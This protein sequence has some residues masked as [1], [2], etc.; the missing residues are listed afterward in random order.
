VTT[1]LLCL[2]LFTLWPIVLVLAI[3]AVRVSQVLTGKKPPNGFPSGTQHGSDWYWRLNRAHVNTLESLPVFASL[4]LTAAVLHLD[5]P[6]FATLATTV[7]AAR[8]G[9]TLAHVF[10]GGNMHVNVRFTFFVVQLTCF[11]WMGLK[12]ATALHA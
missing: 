1:S 3:G 2:V 9:Q 7:V 6:A 12:L 11:L 5:D 10:G 8:A 4:V